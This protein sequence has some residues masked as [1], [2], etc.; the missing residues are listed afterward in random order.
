MATTKAELAATK[1]ELERLRVENAELKAKLGKNSS[2]SSKPPSTDP[3]SKPKPKPK[4]S[5]GRGRKRG[6]QPGHQRHLAPTPDH[7]DAVRKH[8]A[9]TCGNCQADL[10][11]GEL[12]GSVVHHYTYELPEIRPIVT[13]DQCCDVACPRCGKVTPASLPPEVP[14]GGF[15]PRV[16]AM[17]GMVRG[18][19]RQSVRQASAVMTRLYHV[20][21]SMGAV[22]KVQNQVSQ[23][24]ASPHAE[25]HQYA[26]EHPRPHA[27]ETGWWQDKLRAWLW[28][29]VCGPVAVFLVRSKRN[30]AVAKELLGETFRGILTTDRWASYNWIAPEL[31]QLCWAHLKR[32]F[33]SF[34]DYGAEGKRLGT[35]LLIETRKLFRLWKRIRDGTLTRSKFQEKM[36]PVRERI[37]EL[38]K[39]GE[40]QTSAPKVKGMCK[41]ILKLRK[42]LFSF[43]DVEGVEP[44]NNL[45]ERVIRFASIWRRLCFGSDSKS[46]AEFVERFLTVRATLRLQN[47]DLYSFLVE[48]CTAAQQGTPPPS[49]LPVAVPSAESLDDPLPIAA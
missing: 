48:A 37:E 40:R 13:D 45:A 6:G 21:M 14:R 12:T 8:R 22:C 41:Q 10:R 30:A 2:N 38:L 39:E 35:K 1:G 18:E 31:R 46:G 17:I 7:V 20:P 25:A 47:R 11:D 4:K 36:V 44:T 33:T 3:P 49:L 19:L 26:K 42:A 9:E 32:D 23:A 29:A 24:L 34:L 16:Q 27:D 28:V 15:G 5:R 43:V